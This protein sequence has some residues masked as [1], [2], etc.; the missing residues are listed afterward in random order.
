MRARVFCL[1]LIC[2]RRYTRPSVTW[3]THV[4]H[5]GVRDRMACVILFVHEFEMV[6]VGVGVG[7]DCCWR[8]T[9]HLLTFECSMQILHLLRL[10][11]TEFATMTS[12]YFNYRL[13]EI[14]EVLR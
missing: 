12:I 10:S 9:L 13:S 1:L 2:F 8:D 7:A 3:R 11:E 6:C 5:T 14:D 4:P